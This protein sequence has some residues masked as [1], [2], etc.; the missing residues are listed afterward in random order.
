MAA[1]GGFD[2]GIIPDPVN[3]NKDGIS[4]NKVSEH[5][6]LGV[7]SV[8]YPLSETRCLLGLTTRCATNATP[9]GLA[10]T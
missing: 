3:L 9:E 10:R 7:P 5:S 2:I 8:A 1:P 4:M 6:A